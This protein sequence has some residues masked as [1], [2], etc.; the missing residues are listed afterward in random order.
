MVN[1]YTIGYTKKSL[2]EFTQLLMKNK[3]EKVIDI[4]LKNTSQ[5]AGFA[6]ANDL[7][8][9][10]ETFLHINYMHIPLLS[11][12]EEIFQKY[13]ETKDWDACKLS[14]NKLIEKRQANEILKKAINKHENICLLCS[15][16]LPNKCHRRLLAEYYQRHNHAVKVIH[17]TSKD[18]KKS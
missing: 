5:L 8:Y 4:R 15:E 16:D 3:I 2:E 9:I 11:P 14:I 6:K 1:I 17:L 10:L 18:K 12:T 13:K 7:Q